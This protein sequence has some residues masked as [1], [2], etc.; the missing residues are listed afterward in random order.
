MENGS[1]GE[2]EEDTITLAGGETSDH[3][4]TTA[5]L[6]DDVSEADSKQDTL[7][8]QQ[9]QPEQAQQAPMDIGNFFSHFGTGPVM[10]FSMSE[11]F[12]IANKK[13]VCGNLLMVIE[14]LS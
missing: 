12:G 8:Q 10:C 11:C 2:P 9:Q 14:A 13:L 5:G 7:K 1:R 4:S 3:V 6:A